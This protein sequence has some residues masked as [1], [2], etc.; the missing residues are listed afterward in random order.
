MK[1]LIKKAK[2][3]WLINKTVG[4]GFSLTLLISIASSF[5]AY[6]STNQILQAKTIDSKIVYEDIKNILYT[7]S[8]IT[9]LVLTASAVIIFRDMAKRNYFEKELAKAKEIAE[10][11][12]KVKE[13]LGKV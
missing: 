4:L 12:V 5:I 2:P 9:F 6:K 7:G 13:R 11:S 8:F 3:K 1:W 10:H